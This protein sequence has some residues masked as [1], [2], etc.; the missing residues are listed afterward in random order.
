MKAIRLPGEEIMIPSVIEA[1][2]R[3]NLHGFEH[4][5]HTSAMTAQALAAAEHVTGF[6]VAKP[7]VVRVGGKLA[8]AVVS[9][10]ERVSLGMLEEA[11]GERAELV[12]EDEFAARFVP[13]EAGAE[14][15]LSLFGLPIFADE[16]FLQADRIV[17]PA[18]THEDS[19]VIDTHEWIV[20]ERVQPIANLGTRYRLQ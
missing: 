10:A 5:Q 20:H 11:T 14:P 7:V 16:K 17:M 12:P 6:K 19:V 15:A 3:E 1:H 13:C 2:L 4:H 18:G 8:I 9:A